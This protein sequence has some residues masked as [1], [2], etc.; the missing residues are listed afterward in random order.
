MTEARK[1]T[2]TL[3]SARL[4][5]R[6]WEP[7][8]LPAFATLNADPRVMEFMA[9]RLDRAASDALAT[10]IDEH[11]ERHGFGLWA[12]EPR[13]GPRF[14]G[15]I[16]LSIPRFTTAFTPCVEIGWRLAAEHWGRGYATEGAKEALRHGFERI[17]LE[18]I[19]SFTTRVNLRSRRVMQK[20]GMRH[21]PVDDF[22]HPALAADHPLRPHV[23]YRLSNDAWKMQSAR[24]S[25]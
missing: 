22:E 19:V 2:P 16:G 4:L 11:F 14:I 23:L 20:L 7:D 25:V 1:A 6:P 12:V 13:G 9:A 10:R 24:N 3:E 17:G 8:D 5:L 18:E 21:D 15:F